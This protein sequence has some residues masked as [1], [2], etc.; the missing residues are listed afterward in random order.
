[1]LRTSVHG[2]ITR[3]QLARTVAG[4]PLFT[5]SAY[6]LEDTLIDT[7]CP[8]TAGELA[9]FS[10]SR[11]VQRI[12]NTHAHE[13]H[14]GGNAR[15][16]LPALA[17]ALA[18][19]AMVCPPRIP[20]YRRIVWGQPSPCRA[21]A[22]GQAVAIGPYTLRVV[23]TPGH[24]SD[25]TCFFQ[26]RQGWLFTGDLFLSP[27]TRY[28]RRDEDAHAL[29]RS[30]ELVRDLAPALLLC[31][32]AGFVADPRPAL[33]RKIAF[34]RELADRAGELRQQGLAVATIARRL[35]GPEGWM[36]L[37]SRG[38]FSKR[39]LIRSLLRS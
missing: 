10:R 5:V 26:E 19:P 15:L 3:I 20:L 38:E 29:L 23:P 36:T 9:A 6:L 17:P 4:R 30:L 39:N 32:H 8:H 18:L 7:G 1:M 28:L 35:L 13:D 37:A 16:G 33:T 2:P 34:L 14:F 12:L 11:S 24:S 25:H 22:L 27:H 21:E 31:S